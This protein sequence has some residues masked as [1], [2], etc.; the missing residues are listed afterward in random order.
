MLQKGGKWG[1]RTSLGGQKAIHNNMSKVYNF[2]HFEM[3][4]RA[5]YNLIGYLYNYIQYDYKHKLKTVFTWGRKEL[6]TCNYLLINGEK[7]LIIGQY[8][9]IIVLCCLKGTIRQSFDKVQTTQLYSQFLTNNNR[10]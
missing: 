8:T 2:P 1:E 10:L 5:M 9:V 3:Y 7:A 4:V 6:K